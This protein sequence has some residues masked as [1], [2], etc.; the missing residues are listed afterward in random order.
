M[1]S[2]MC[3]R[4]ETFNKSQIW[5]LAESFM[6]SQSSSPS[7]SRTRGKINALPPSPH[8]ARVTVPSP[9]LFLCT[10]RLLT[11]PACLPKQRDRVG[12]GDPLS[13]PETKWHAS[14]VQRFSRSKGCKPRSL[15]GVHWLTDMCQALYWLTVF[16]GFLSCGIRPC[17]HFHHLLWQDRLYRSAPV[18][19]KSFVLIFSS[20]W[21]SLSS[22]A[23]HT[24]RCLAQSIQWATNGWIARK[25]LVNT[26]F[27][28]RMNC[29]HF[30]CPSDLSWWWGLALMLQK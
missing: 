20:Q 19:R 26:H 16:L 2:P 25:F 7:H 11:L 23:P 12:G 21:T 5:L 9:Q 30:F 15:F 29:C 4:L 27:D 1:R 28:L 18:L 8:Q 24:Q 6:H 10:S 3:M 14:D 22:L 13:L 17:Y